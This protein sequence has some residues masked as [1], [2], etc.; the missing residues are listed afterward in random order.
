M[1]INLLGIADVLIVYKD[2]EVV[3]MNKNFLPLEG[4]TYF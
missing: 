2:Y 1:Y 3:P 4:D